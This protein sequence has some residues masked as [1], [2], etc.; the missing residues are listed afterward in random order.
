MALSGSVTSANGYTD[1]YGTRRLTFSWTATQ[2]I[3]NNTSTIS[4]T[5]STSGGYPYW[6]YYSKTKVVIDG[7]TVYYVEGR[8]QIPPGTIATGTVTLTHNSVGDRSFSASVQAGIYEHAVNCT[9]SGTW[10]LDTIPR[11]STVTGSNLVFGQAGTLNISR[12]SSSFSDTISY[13]LGAYT[14]TIATKTQAA[15][16]SWTPDVNMMNAIPAATTAA[17]SITC[18]TYNGNTLIATKTST[19]SVAVP[20]GVVPT[21]SAQLSNTV[22]TFGTYT[23][24]VSKVRVQITA[25]G[26]YGANIA[27][28]TTTFEGNNYSGAD[29]TT[30]VIS[31]SGSITATI[32]V[33]DSRGRRTTL[34]ETISVQAYSTPKM[35]FSAHRCDS[36]GT[37]DDMGAYV[38]AWIKGTASAVTNNVVTL[39]LRKRQAGASAWTTVDIT[40]DT[41]VVSDV[42][43]IADSVIPADDTLSWEFQAVVTD[44]INGITQTIPISVGY[45]TIDFLKGGRG[46]SFGTTA[47]S[48]GFKCAMDA[49]FTGEVGVSGDAEFSGDVAHKN[50]SNKTMDIPTAISQLWSV[51]APTA[52][53]GSRTQS[54]TVTVDMTDYRSTNGNTGVWAALLVTVCWVVGSEGAAIHLIHATQGAL[55]MACSEV[56]KGSNGA[57]ASMSG[58]TLTITFWDTAGGAY[59]V[60]P[61]FGKDT[62]YDYGKDSYT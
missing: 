21:A 58:T 47:L 53:H 32:V 16:V 11:A 51:I 57:T 38:N 3:A 15:S 28:Y 12:A 9:A 4:W 10:A 60:I 23:Q 36:G 19:V 25:S 41:T 33:T 39:S 50:S 44:L 30:N 62:N 31:G 14:G 24:S 34:T 42:E 8:Q 1:E 27:S 17:V 59:A 7:Q 48:D 54:K 46:I 61:L 40:S 26:Q 45:A 20:S 18:Q 29:V 55:N 2:S 37:A 6:I 49:E 56:Y 13:T 5:L 35:E 52:R 22:T 43:K